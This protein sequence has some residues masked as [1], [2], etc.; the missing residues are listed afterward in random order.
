[1]ILDVEAAAQRLAEGE[2]VA[3]PTETVYGLGVDAGSNA[4]LARLYQLKG[5]EP[6]RALSVLVPD[7]AGLERLVPQL[8]DVA[9]KLGRCFWPGPLTLVVAVAGEELSLV[10]SAYGVGF[11]CSAHPT[12]QA[13]ARASERPVI[14]TSCNRSGAA[15]CRNPEQIQQA[16]G[17]ELPIVSGE[18][19]GGLEPSTVVAVASSG[20]TLLLREGSIPY[21]RLLEELAA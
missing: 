19:A 2:V 20:R 11:R 5:R 16:F 4:A 3:Y 6:A 1:M 21:T 14:A 9:K 12:A 18:P 13:L 7:L 8:P 15:P 10:S 17:S